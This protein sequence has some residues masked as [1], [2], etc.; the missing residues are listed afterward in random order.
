MNDPIT[1]MTRPQRAFYREVGERL[2]DARNRQ[3]LS[4]AQLGQ[5]IGVTGVAVHYWEHAKTAPTLWHIRQVEHVL[6]EA[7]A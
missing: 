2:R 5:R 1:V 6:G 4:Q 3:G 7:V